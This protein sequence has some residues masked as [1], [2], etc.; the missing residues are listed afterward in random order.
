[1]LISQLL[2]L[3][4]MV[5]EGLLS[6]PIRI[7]DHFLSFN[8]S[9]L[10]VSKCKSI[11]SRLA[12]VTR[13]EKNAFFLFCF[14]FFSFFSSNN[15]N[16][17]I[18][19]KLI[20]YL[21]TY[22]ERQF[23]TTMSSF[24]SISG[25]GGG[26]FPFPPF[27]SSGLFVYSTP[28]FFTPTILLAFVVL[29]GSLRY[30]LQTKNVPWQDISS[31]L[32]SPDR[33]LSP[34]SRL[35]VVL[36]CV[37]TSSFFLDGLVVIVRVLLDQGS[38]SV[39]LVYYIGIS[40]LAW[41][42]SLACL[43]DESH[44]FSKWY[45][46]QYTYF[47][48]A[49]AG[50]TLVAW[51]WLMG[52]YKPRPGKRNSL[53]NDLGS[54]KWVTKRT[55]LIY[56]GSIFTI[57][58]YILLGTFIARYVLEIITFTL[59]IIQMITTTRHIERNNRE[60]EPLL[61]STS[62]YGATTTATDTNS[63]NPITTSSNK[64]KDR[65]DFLKKLAKVMPF[66]WPHNNTYLQSLVLICFILMCIGLAI[67]VFTPLQI[68]TIVDR[69]NKDPQSF[70][71]A[72]VLAYVAFKFLQGGSGLI[73]A[74][75]NWLWI[76]IGQYTTREISV[77][78]FAHL[79]SLSLHYH[80][81]RKTGEVLRIVDRGTNSIVQLL[82]QI[83]FSIFPA[84]ANILIAVVVFSVK[85]SL[86]FGIITFVTMALYLYTTI[87][88]TEWR[89]AFRRKMNE[90][91]NF[92][93]TKAV[94]SLLNFETVKYYNAEGFEVDRYDKAIVEY[95]KADYINSV[96]LNVLNLAQNAVI[97]GGLLAASLLFAW[98]VS[99]GRL[100]AGNFVTFNV[101][102][103]QLYTPL[104][105]FGTYYRMIQQNFIDMEKMFDLF[106]VEET[107]KDVEGAG[108]LNVTEGRV[109]FDNVSFAY[110]NRQTALNGISFSIP[111]G[112]QV[113]K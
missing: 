38:L 1:M 24:V 96:S 91:D 64:K 49:A 55:K 47:A 93:R 27:Y 13:D 59:S 10:F 26:F 86:P 112:S 34:L 108:D 30:F 54:E 37:V 43:L 5:S 69:F 76:P 41:V 85:F 52:I 25:E 92:A 6:E 63:N 53:L 75:Q 82:S 33:R 74:V 68:G 77:K 66:I 94:D 23:H 78:L 98:E 14:S 44:K 105:F 99:K 70:A 4:V 65:K 109:V 88:L 35:I 83:V 11:K 58:D 51:L 19:Q 3:Y 103:M 2:F 17:Y 57:Y 106:E 42:I 12:G 111:K 107:V 67:N 84:L 73:Q 104:H 101:Y 18:T 56:T 60:I 9:L 22:K 36:S 48:M 8:S 97:T 16:T 102:M 7:H 113:G 31:P 62:N 87:T 46:L 29:V 28:L 15:S 90:L 32:I 61:A 95:Q 100:T 89:T 81:N 21:S 20:L 80:I 50:E 39:M 71:W 45:W 79:H 110:D 72:A 40:W